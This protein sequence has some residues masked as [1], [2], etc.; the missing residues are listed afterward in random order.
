LLDG[1]LGFTETDIA[2]SPSLF[3]HPNSVALLIDAA[4]RP[5]KATFLYWDQGKISA[6]VEFP[7]DAALLSEAERNRLSET[8]VDANQPRQKSAVVRRALASALTSKKRSARFLTGT[9][10]TASMLTA[11]TAL[12]LR[13]RKR[14][15]LRHGAPPR[16]CPPHPLR[17]WGSGSSGMAAASSFPGNR[18]A[19]PIAAANFGIILVK[20]GNDRREIVLTRDQLQTG[21]VFYTATSDQMDIELTV[22]SPERNL[23]TESLVVVLQ[24][25]DIAAVDSFAGQSAPDP[26]SPTERSA[27]PAP[28]APAKQTTQ[29]QVPRRVFVRPASRNAGFALSIEKPPPPLEAKSYNRYR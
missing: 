10:V 4:S 13:Y 18:N 24:S 12:W 8:E 22:V 26:S 19:P 23:T 16:G 11:G 14:Q 1:G 25:S 27:I 21:K 29:P 9:I 7:L 20:S 5:A 15:H 3:S 28:S 6:P 17:A 2:L